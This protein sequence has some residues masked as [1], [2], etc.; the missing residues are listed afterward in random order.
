MSLLTLY[1]PVNYGSAP[2]SEYLNV[3]A[4]FWPLFSVRM[5]VISGE[6]CNY[7]LGVSSDV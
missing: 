2:F 4:P 5:L 3:R 6:D 1:P 7:D